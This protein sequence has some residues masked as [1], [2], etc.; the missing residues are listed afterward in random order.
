MTEAVLNYV[1]CAGEWIRRYIGAQC[2]SEDGIS[3]RRLWYVAK[4]DFGRN[5]YSEFP[6]WL[7]LG[8][9]SSPLAATQFAQIPRWSFHFLVSLG[10]AVSN[11]VILITVFKLK[12]QDGTLTWPGLLR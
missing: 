8:A 1:G 3:T 2:R 10:L 6:V 9:F 11:T 12:N 7:G 4:T 5:I